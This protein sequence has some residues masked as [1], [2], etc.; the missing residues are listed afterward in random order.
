MKPATFSKSLAPYTKNNSIF[1]CPSDSG[2]SPSYSLNSSLAG[3]AVAKV[4]SPATTVLF[5]EGANGKLTY[6]HDGKAVVCFADGHV[7]FV[8]AADSNKLRWKP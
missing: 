5:Y 6:R 7:K 1:K 4:Q 2:P 3:I 8:T